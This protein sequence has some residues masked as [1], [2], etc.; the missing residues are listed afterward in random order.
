MST[1]TFEFRTN[2]QVRETMTTHEREIFT[3]DKH[4]LLVTFEDGGGY[5]IGITTEQA[6]QL[7][8]QLK[9]ANL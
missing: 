4:E 5:R 2:D 8:Q 1:T 6:C 3:S 9:D 7:L